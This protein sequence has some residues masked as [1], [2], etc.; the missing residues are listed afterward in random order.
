MFEWAFTVLYIFKSIIFAPIFNPK[1]EHRFLWA[2]FMKIWFRGILLNKNAIF[3]LSRSRYFRLID[4]E[5]QLQLLALFRPLLGWCQHAKC[6]KNSKISRIFGNEWLWSHPL[7]Y[8]NCQ[9]SQKIQDTSSML[10]S[11]FEKVDLL[12]IFI[13]Y[14]E[15]HKKSWVSFTTWNV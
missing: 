10:N 11:F 9:C 15:I 14:S 8:K 1:F 13:F 3:F 12:S 6:W 4:E 5:N 2:G 7:N